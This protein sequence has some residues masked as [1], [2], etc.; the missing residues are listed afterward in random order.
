MHS[1]LAPPPRSCRQARACAYAPAGAAEAAIA[2]CLYDRARNLAAATGD[3]SLAARA[4]DARRRALV[5][6][7]DA[8]GLA[9]AGD[10][11]AAVELLASRGEW[12]RAHEL[13]SGV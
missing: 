4:N 3:A 7:G 5:A 12:D 6:G 10:A 2:G 9:A 8:E 13:V 11:E 1:E